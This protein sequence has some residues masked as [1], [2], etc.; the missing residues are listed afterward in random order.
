MM[1]KREVY[2]SRSPG[3]PPDLY[4]LVAESPPPDLRD[5]V[6]PISAD[7]SRWQL[8]VDPMIGSRFSIDLYKHFQLLVGGDIGGFGV[9]SH[10]TYSILGLLGYRFQMFGRGA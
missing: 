2:Y 7:V 1:G 5:F 9:G 6:P 3:V 8:W 4:A 10:F